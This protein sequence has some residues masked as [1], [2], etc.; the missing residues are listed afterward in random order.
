MQT[1]NNNYNNLTYTQLC[2]IK[3]FNNVAN[4]KNEE[5]LWH[6]LNNTQT[7]FLQ[8]YLQQQN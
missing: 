3:L 8:Q 1:T 5:L 6:A 4:T 7:T 2:L